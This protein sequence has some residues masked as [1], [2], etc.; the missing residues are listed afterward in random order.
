MRSYATRREHAIVVVVAP[1]FPDA[2][3]VVSDL[4]DRRSGANASAEAATAAARRWKSRPARTT[5]RVKDEARGA[6]EREEVGG[7]LTSLADV[8]AW[9]VKFK[10]DDGAEIVFARRTWR[11]GENKHC[12]LLLRPAVVRSCLPSDK[13]NRMHR[14][15]D[16]IK[17][18]SYAIHRS[19]LVETRVKPVSSPALFSTPWET[20]RVGQYKFYDLIWFI[21]FVY[22]LA[23]KRL[24]LIIEM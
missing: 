10:C 2:R 17:Y 15:P 6:R 24:G 18:Y 14:E 16:D 13:I 4:T 23:N 8:M 9:Y 12:L 1:D 20:E 5:M 7:D 21:Y 22:Y 11:H 3:D 19:T